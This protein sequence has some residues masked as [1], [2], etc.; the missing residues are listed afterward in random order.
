[1]EDLN[2][3]LQFI[4][5]IGKDE[6]I[7]IKYLKIV[8]NGWLSKAYRSLFD[9]ES[10]EKTFLFIQT[11]IYEATHLIDTYYKYNKKNDPL[12]IKSIIMNLNKCKIG[13]KNLQFT[14]D[15][16]RITVCK[17]RTLIIYIDSFF[18]Q[19]SNDY[20]Q[21]LKKNN[22]SFNNKNKDDNYETTA[23][24]IYGNIETILSNNKQNRNQF[25]AICNTDVIC[26]G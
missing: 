8:S 7:N 2:S 17:L 14:Y 6:R 5:E 16:D 3:I 18:T 26:I 12:L 15:H 9:N 25:L 24:I 20:K 22:I 4:S 21:M 13:I 1:M 19:M 11:K 10:R 23:N